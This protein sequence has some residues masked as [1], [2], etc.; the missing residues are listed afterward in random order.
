M[1]P[2]A[3]HEQGPYTAPVPY[4]APPYSPAPPPYYMPVPVSVPTSGAAV[5]S[6]IAGI[7]SIIGGFCLLVPPF[8]AIIAGHMA[9]G[10]TRSG[11]RGGH[12]MV[13]TGLILGYMTGIGVAG[14]FLLWLMGMVASV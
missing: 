13:I 1:H 5:V 3:P 11:Q 8:I 2:R 4:S 9:Y 10:S 7:F 6:L 14:I 12:G